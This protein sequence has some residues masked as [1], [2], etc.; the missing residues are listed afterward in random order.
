MTRPLSS[1]DGV[2]AGSC[3]TSSAAASSTSGSTQ[4]KMPLAETY[5]RGS[6][7]QPDQS[8]SLGSLSRAPGLP[9]EIPRNALDRVHR[10]QVRRTPVVRKFVWYRPQTCS[11]QLYSRANPGHLIKVRWSSPVRAGSRPRSCAVASIEPQRS[12]RPCIE[13]VHLLRHADRPER[14]KP[15]ERCHSQ[16]ICAPL[17]IVPTKLRSA[18][19]RRYRTAG[20]FSVLPASLQAV[21]PPQRLGFPFRKAELGRRALPV[22]SACSGARRPAVGW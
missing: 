14:I 5:S 1:I 21:G 18:P 17:H 12:G 4:P 16:L 20:G 9:A 6:E 19:N 8:I 10:I 3:T 15:P 7:T 13:A 11:S 22:R 2:T